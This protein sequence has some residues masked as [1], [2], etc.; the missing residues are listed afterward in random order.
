MHEL[1][2]ASPPCYLCVLSLGVCGWCWRHLFCM[3]EGY[4][5]GNYTRKEMI[6]LKNVKPKGSSLTNS[7]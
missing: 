6:I 5:T 4:A 2:F 3:S 7:E 1:Y